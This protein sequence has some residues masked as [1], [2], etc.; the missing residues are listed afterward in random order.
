MEGLRLRVEGVLG[1]GLL[2]FTWIANFLLVLLV[3]A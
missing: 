3:K 1:S 2:R